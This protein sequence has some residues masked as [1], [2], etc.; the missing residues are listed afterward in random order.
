MVAVVF[1]AAVA[2]QQS[3][4][5]PSPVDAEVLES[6]LRANREDAPPIRLSQLADLVAVVDFQEAHRWRGRVFDISAGEY[7]LVGVSRV[8]FSDGKA[9][10]CVESRN[11]GQLFLLESGASGWSVVESYPAWT[12]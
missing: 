3:L 8:G 7:S 1:F 12:S 5:M 10:L 2:H 6:F 9:L 4:D 11:L